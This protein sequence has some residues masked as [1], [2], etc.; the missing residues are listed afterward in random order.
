VAVTMKDTIFCDVT[1]YNHFIF[2]LLVGWDYVPNTVATSGLLYKPQMIDE[3][4][5][6]AIGG[7][8]IG[9]GNRST[10]R[11]PAPAPLCPPQI[12][13]DQAWARTPGRR[14]GK[15]ATNR[16]RYGAAPV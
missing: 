2:I 7:M 11:K 1:Q 13:H 15:P 5:C 16:L 12:P 9:R 10:R 6:G 3:D 8:N 14:G 4:D